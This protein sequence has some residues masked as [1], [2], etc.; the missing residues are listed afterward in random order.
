MS[1]LPGWN[2]VKEQGPARELP[3]ALFLT[4]STNRKLSPVELEPNTTERLRPVARPPFAC[5]TYVSIR[6]TCSDV[7]GF[8]SGGCYVRAGFTAPLAERLDATAVG[9]TD[10]EVARNEAWLIDSAFAR[11]P[12]RGAMRKFTRIPQD[13]ARGGRDLRLHVGGDCLTE[14]GAR[15]LAAAAKR[16]RHRGGGAVWTYTHSWRVIPRAA[17]GSISVLASCETP[18]HVV[19]ARGRG[20]APALVVRE[21]P[22]RRAFCVSGIVGRVVPCPAEAGERTCVQCRLCFDD[23]ALLERAAVIG[24]AA[25]GMA[26]AEIRRQLPVLQRSA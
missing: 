25:H 15:L 21:F 4:T 8:K 10:V 19:E 5:S 2:V 3:G 23:Q 13:G 6:S 20:Y 9:L 26:Q 16:W 24:F 17:W 7:C 14:A 1:L 11:R 12:H 22:D 18:E